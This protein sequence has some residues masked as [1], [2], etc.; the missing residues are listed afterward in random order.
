[1][2]IN[3]LEFKPIEKESKIGMGTILKLN[4]GTSCV[5]GNLVGNFEYDIGPYY[6]EN[7]QEQTHTFGLVKLGTAY[8]YNQEELIKSDFDFLC[9]DGL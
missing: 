6:T 4:D 1:M 2:E 7:K 9:N 8:D 5:V 3:L